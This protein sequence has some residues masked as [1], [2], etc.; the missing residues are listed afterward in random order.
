MSRF[1]FWLIVLYTALWAKG[2]NIL[3]M[4]LAEDNDPTVVSRFDREIR[5]KLAVLPDV[6]IT[7]FIETQKMKK[8]IEFNC[9]STVS[10]SLVQSLMKITGDSTMVVWGR[11]E[12][13]N[14][15]PKRYIVFGARAVGKLKVVLTIYSISF[16]EYTYIG[17]IETET[18]I[19]KPPVF[20]RNVKRVTHITAA[21]REEI[22]DKLISESTEKT[23]TAISAVVRH[24]LVRGAGSGIPGFEEEEVP[25]I[26]NLFEIPVIDGESIPEEE[27]VLHQQQTEESKEPEAEVQPGGDVKEEE[28]PEVE[29][30]NEVPPLEE[31]PTEKPEGESLPEEGEE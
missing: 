12:N 21:D 6:R 25:S 16:R 7:D 4:G 1:F 3:F 11:V 20:F 17:N 13:L 22:I 2:L 5:E 15:E 14:I 28:Q 19:P 30:I 18:H 29:I 27:P 9:H 23:A 31:Q 10:R 8:R 24:G 26:E